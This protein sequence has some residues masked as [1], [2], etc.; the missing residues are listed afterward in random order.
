[1]TAQTSDGSF[2]TLPSH[3]LGYVAILAAI[4]TGGIHLVLGRGVLGFN[5]LLGALFILNGLGFLGGIGLYLSRYWQRELYLVATGY[6]VVTILALFV[7]QG[8][9]L[10]AFYMQGELNP[11]AVV[12]KVAE[13]VVAVV[14]LYLYTELTG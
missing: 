8:A 9:S 1:M 3:P 10:D 4:V 7:F 11:M 13:L 14:T 2:I 6:A 5:Q 12:A